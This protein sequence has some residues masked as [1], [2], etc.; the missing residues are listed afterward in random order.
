MAKSVS[1]KVGQLHIREYKRKDS[2]E[3]FYA[4]SGDLASLKL[5]LSIG[6]KPLERGEDAPEATE[7]T[8]THG[9]WQLSGGTAV[10]QLGVAWERPITKGR[11]KDKAPMFSIA[12]NHPDLP[13]WMG[14]LAAFPRDENGL[15]HIEHQRQRAT[16]PEYT[17]SDDDDEIPY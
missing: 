10:A 3:V 16:Q 5:Q 13:D 11:F 1:T 12:L 2:G 15:Y 9:V 8:P 17:S 6:M 4:G 14:Q 7:D